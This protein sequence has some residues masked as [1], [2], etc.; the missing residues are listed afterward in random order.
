[1]GDDSGASNHMTGDKRLL[2]TYNT[3]NVPRKVFTASSSTS[4]TILDEGEVVLEVWNGSGYPLVGM[5]GYLH[6]QR[7][8]RNLFSK[9]LRYMGS[10]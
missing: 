8:S 10:H 7:L 6:V 3:L 5:K 1:M 4:L 2:K 9:V